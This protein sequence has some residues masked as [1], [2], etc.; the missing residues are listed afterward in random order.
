MANTLIFG[1]RDTEQKIDLSGLRPGWEKNYIVRHYNTITM[2]NGEER[3]DDT[4]GRIQVY[5]VNTFNSLNE[6]SIE[7]NPKTGEERQIPSQFAQAG[8]L[9]DILHDPI[10]EAASSG[11]QKN[12][13]DAIADINACETV[14]EVDA[15]I[16][17]ETRKGVLAAAEKRKASL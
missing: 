1:N 3:E 17:G 4:T 14:E 13:K 9:L 8:L 6:P 15:L 5:D 12:S 10:G 2:G 16:V 11:G 7:R